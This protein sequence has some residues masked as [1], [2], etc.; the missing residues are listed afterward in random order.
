METNFKP[1]AAKL[2]ASYMVLLP[3]HVES[4]GGRRLHDGDNI[5][6]I[7]TRGLTFDWFD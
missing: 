1:A 6:I 4:S 7:D 3:A 2:L 5:I